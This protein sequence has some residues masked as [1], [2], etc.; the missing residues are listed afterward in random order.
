M[1]YRKPSIWHCTWF[2][3]SKCWSEFGWLPSRWRGLDALC[4]FVAVILG[5][6]PPL[7]LTNCMQTV[8]LPLGL[9]SPGAEGSISRT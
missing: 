5:E 8:V 2:G 6:H 9:L 4:L 3:F 1:K 7:P